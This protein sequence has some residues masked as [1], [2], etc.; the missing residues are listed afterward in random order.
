MTGKGR[1]DE[2]RAGSW[3]DGIPYIKSEMCWMG[4]DCTH[5][6]TRK[7]CLFAHSKEEQVKVNDQ[8]KQFVRARLFAKG[9]PET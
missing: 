6:G 4:D 8:R 1:Y 9:L 7:G 2:G 5:K 3:L